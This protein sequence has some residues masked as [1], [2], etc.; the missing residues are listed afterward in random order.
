MEYSGHAPEWDEVVFRGDPETRSFMAFWLQ[1]DRVLAGMSVNV[2][3][4]TE[5]VEALIRGRNAVD[6]AALV[7]PDTPLIA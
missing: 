4:T 2:P 3:D 1:D 6:R 7:D 5:P